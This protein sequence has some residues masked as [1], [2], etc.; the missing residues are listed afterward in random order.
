MT[1]ST[2]VGG[3]LTYDATDET[4]FGSSVKVTRILSGELPASATNIVGGLSATVELRG[5]NRIAGAPNP[6]VGADRLAWLNTPITVEVG[7]DGLTVPVFTGRVSQLGAH[8]A[9]HS[10]EID[11]R[12][13]AGRLTAAVKLPPYGSYANRT[14]LGVPSVH[15]TNTQAVITNILHSNG[16]RMTPPPRASCVLSIPG[17]GGWLADIGWTVPQGA[18]TPDVW[19]ETGRFGMAPIDTAETLKGLLSKPCNFA[20]LNTSQV[21]FWFRHTGADS[22]AFIALQMVD[23]SLIWCTIASNTAQVWVR[24]GFGGSLNVLTSST[25]STGWHHIC[26][27]FDFGINTKLWIDGTLNASSTTPWGSTYTP[28]PGPINQLLVDAG[29][30]QGINFYN[31]AGTLAAPTSAVMAFVAQADLS[32]GALDLSATPNVDGRDAWSVLQEIAQA[33]LGMVGFSES[34]R[35]FFK[36]RADLAAATTPVATWGLDLVEELATTA[37]IDGILSRAT[38][39]VK[40]PIGVFSG[41]GADSPSTIAIPSVLADQVYTVPPGTSSVLLTGSVPYLPTT[42][43]VSVV[44]APSGAWGSAVGMALCTDAYGSTRYT[45]P[46]VSATIA[47]ASQ[48]AWR[49]TF[50]NN[51]GGTVYTAWPNDWT[52]SGGYVTVPFDRAAGAPALWVNGYSFPA[53]ALGDVLVDRSN[54]ASIAAWGERVLPLGDS[55]W[56]QNPTQVE[57]FADAILAATSYPRAQVDDVT[58][59]ADPRWQLGD[60]VTLHD[61][62]GRLPDIVARITSIELTI[63]LEVEG[64]MV[65]KYGLR[66]V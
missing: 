32:I 53:G 65:G 60:P 66:Q 20:N 57:A 35:F 41:V 10:A 26:F 29:R 43:R 49:V 61:A 64:G 58:V 54:S 52:A 23:G 48:T 6:L 24:K 15:R 30:V 42:H 63:S 34:G 62:R 33:E 1:A 55:V 18:P 36:S 50:Q 3:G 44:T 14:T 11:G 2:L 22:P 27:E 17:V 59:P 51:S 9:S 13:S 5:D 19:L 25:L 38:A 12:D 39:T 7:Y 46:D 47:P 4:G 21:E 37:S 31:V 40:R 45:G 28:N 56:R 8:E 16:I